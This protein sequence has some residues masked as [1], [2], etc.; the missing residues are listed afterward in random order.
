MSGYF[1][2][3]YCKQAL[4]LNLLFLVLSGECYKFKVCKQLS[5]TYNILCTLHFKYL[6]LNVCVYLLD[7]ILIFLEVITNNLKT[8]KHFS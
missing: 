4:T 3:K 2:L 5:R 7:L 1:A 8:K 6:F